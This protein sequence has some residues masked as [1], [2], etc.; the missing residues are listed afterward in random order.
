MKSYLSERNA[1]LADS[2]RE[3]DQPKMKRIIPAVTT[4]KSRS[5]K[6]S[7]AYRKRPFLEFNKSTF[8][9]K[10]SGSNF[11][12]EISVRAAVAVLN[13]NPLIPSYRPRQP[14]DHI[15]RT[16]SIENCVIITIST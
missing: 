6:N 4:T 2:P 16:Y 10:T 13:T 9:F 1:E 8:H 12:F 3:S 5:G 7:R 11:R 15:R 14:A